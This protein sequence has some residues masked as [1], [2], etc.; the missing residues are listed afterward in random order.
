MQRGRRRPLLIVK[1][2]LADEAVRSAYGDFESWIT[3]SLGGPPGLAIEVCRVAA[4]AALP[5]AVELSAAIVT[6]S[7]AMVT[8]RQA[9]ME[10]TAG[11]LAE[12]SATGLPVLGICFGH[13]LLAHGLGGTVGVNPR[14]REVGTAML[15]LDPAAAVDPLLGGLPSPCPVQTTH[16]ESVLELPDGAVHLAATA[17]DPHH[18]FRWGA[19]AWGVQ[20]HPEFSPE[21]MSAYLSSRRSALEEEGQDVDRLLAAIRPSPAGGLV[22]RRFADCASARAAA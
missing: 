5:R 2:G 20:F 14:G 9:W 7:S 15:H 8:W 22:L 11:W 16:V 1:T 3:S 21:V 6:G 13:Q 17:G 4:G 18:A 10:R 12:A 19:A